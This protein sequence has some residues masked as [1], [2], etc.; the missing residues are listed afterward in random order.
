MQLN[1]TIRI[2]LLIITGV[3]SISMLAYSCKKD[4]TNN[5][6]DD[7]TVKDIDGNIYKTV[8]IG[9]QTW[10]AENLRTTRYN[11]STLIPH[12][13]A[14]SSAVL[15]GPYVCTYKYNINSDTI[16]TYGRLYNWYSLNTGKL[17]PKGWH[18]PS[19][20]EWTTL[21]NYLSVN[22]FNYDGSAAATA[23]PG[24]TPE[25]KLGKSLASIT[26]WLQSAVE[27]SVGNTDF[28]AKRNA[29]GFTA[30]PGGARTDV[31]QFN[32]MGIGGFWWTS[33]EISTN[34]GNAY[35]YSLLNNSIGISSGY[36]SK[37]NGFS[38]RCVK[39]NPTK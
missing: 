13:F 3:V 30:F 5:P 19:F 18:I 4:D 35:G 32:Q 28:P 12:P 2:Y 23:A 9:T 10:M 36:A 21:T 15:Y 26:G 17:C 14:K 31:G 38:V 33:T 6:A 7:T 34:T 24:S 29:T 39:D 22:G 11:D 25:N 37:M 20:A 16:K 1:H 27:G 8:T